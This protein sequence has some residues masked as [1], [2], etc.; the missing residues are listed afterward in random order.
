MAFPPREREH[1][2]YTETGRARR[3]ARC[4]KRAPFRIE[5]RQSAGLGTAGLSGRAPR[6]APT[7]ATNTRPISSALIHAFMRSMAFTAD[8]ESHVQSRRR[9]TLSVNAPV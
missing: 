4:A 5:T 2:A 6:A 8:P 3:L 9:G 1:I 7:V